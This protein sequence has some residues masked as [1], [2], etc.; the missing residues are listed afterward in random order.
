MIP[1]QMLVFIAMLV[2]IKAHQHGGCKETDT[3]VTE[4]LY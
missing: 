1:V 3:S 4:F 2:L